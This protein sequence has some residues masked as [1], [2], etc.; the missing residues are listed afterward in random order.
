MFFVDKYRIR[1]Q[2]DVRFNK[3]V[4]EK[5]GLM[6][7][8]G[9]DGGGGG[10]QVGHIIVAGASGV[11]KR[12]FV[13]FLLRRLYGESMLRETKKQ[14]FTIKNYGSN[15]VNVV[16]EMS[17]VHVVFRP[18]NSA[19]DKYVIQ[20]VV[21][22]FMS[23]NARHLFEGR[24]IPHK[25]VII[26]PL[27]TLTR[28]TQT[29]LRR[30]ME[31]YSRNC[32]F[33]LVGHNYDSVITPIQERCTLVVVPV[34]SREDLLGIAERVVSEEGIPP[35]DLED[36]VARAG[37][38][39]NRLLWILDYA[40]SGVTSPP[41]WKASVRSLADWI[42]AAASAAPVQRQERERGELVGDAAGARP[43]EGGGSPCVYDAVDQASFEGVRRLLGDLFIS[44]LEA[45]VLCAGLAKAIL[46]RLSESARGASGDAP[47][48]A[49][50]TTFPVARSAA[51]VLRTV[52]KFNYRIINS[53]RYIMHLEAMVTNLV[54]ELRRVRAAE[55]RHRPV[56]T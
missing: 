5:F 22:E 21:M 52:C 4:F 25:T 37:G 32:R 38:S 27:D 34:P 35:P 10:Y 41:S 11:G 45:N 42:V 8:D 1:N 47:A 9:G 49:D 14:E 53:T 3:D 54:D 39:V 56:H 51:A 23:K 15:H 30:T 6:G 48:A 36:A 7:G 24:E 31:E 20:E 43:G 50:P 33:V 40:K 18:N 2:Q 46:F 28:P 17:P 16:L 19:L 12:T 29:A 44:N 13:D 26:D 55:A